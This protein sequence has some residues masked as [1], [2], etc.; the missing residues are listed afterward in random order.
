MPGAILSAHLKSAI[1]N[2]ALLS[3][4]CVLF[5][6]IGTW[7]LPLI[8]RDEPR[9]AEASREM[10]ELGDYIVPHFNN[11]FRLDKPPFTYWAQVASFKIFG[12]NDF[13]ARFP[14]A[15]AAALVALSTFAWGTRIGGNRVGWWAAIIFTLSLQTFLHAKAA[16]ADMWLVLFI[17]ISQWSGYEL[18]RDRLSPAN[19]TSNIKRLIGGGCSMSRLH[20]DF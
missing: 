5:H 4:G 9:F 14:S 8:D 18:L 16:V 1:R 7:S 12:E 20:S 17:T 2:Y 6:V 19:Q 3:F 15:I 13:A 11:Q 10:I